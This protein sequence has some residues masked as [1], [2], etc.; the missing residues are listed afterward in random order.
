MILHHPQQALQSFL[1]LK[2][3]IFLSFFIAVRQT[4]ANEPA[5]PP[6]PPPPQPP[7]EVEQLPG[8][9]AGD[10]QGLQMQQGI[11]ENLQKLAA[12]KEESN[13]NKK[14]QDEM[15][16][17]MLETQ[18]GMLVMMKEMSGSLIALAQL[19]NVTF[20]QRHPI[21]FDLF[22]YDETAEGNRHDED[23]DEDMESKGKRAK[24]EKDNR[25]GSGSKNRKTD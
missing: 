5:L 3:T 1:Q 13:Q 21:T 10:L 11:L 9:E 20:H 2:I 16:R 18:K 4:A 25:V 12:A 23:S 22:P 8:Q 19:R 6:P 17:G 14:L 15:Q 24:L 7:H